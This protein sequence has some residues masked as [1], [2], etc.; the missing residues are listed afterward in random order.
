V[1]VE[2]ASNRAPIPL[3]RASLDQLPRDIERPRYDLDNVRAGIVH[4]GLGGFHRAHMARYT[5]DLMML[6][7]SALEW[8][9]L[10]AGLLPQ[11]HRMRDALAPQDWLYT[12]AER[13]GS[14]ERAVA[15]GALTGMI[16]AAGASE[17]LLEAIDRPSTRIVSITVTEHGYCLNPSTRRL[18][19]EHPLIRR[20]LAE[21]T[22][23]HSAIGILVEAC[24]RRKTA[25]LPAFT[26]L[27]CDNIPH[28]GDVT[29]RAVLDLAAQRDRGLAAWIEDN[30]RFPNGM[31]D[32]ITPVTR[33]EDIAALAA[34]H[35]IADNWPVFS[36]TF[37]QWVV[38]DDF[39]CRRP[40]WEDVGVQFVRDVAPY[41]RMKLRLLNASHLAIAGPA[42]LM[43]YEY[44]DEAMG[45]ASLRLYMR[46]LMDRE[47]GPTLLPVPGIDLEA[48]KVTL[49]ERFA[50]TAIKDLV[51]RVNT[52]A[53]LNYLIDPIVDQ[54]RSGGSIDLLALAV[55]AWI[56]RVR[57][58]DEAGRPIE[59]RHPLAGLLRERAVAG[60]RDPLPVL[61][62]APLFG[63]LA[64][65]RQF[66]SA[67]GKWLAALYD[68]GAARTLAR[69]VGRESRSDPEDVH[70]TAP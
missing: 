54:L 56:R 42:R 6:S 34:R 9:I 13:N 4:L 59:I 21:P 5:H 46:A 62:I 17:S 36:E 26:I 30:V 35:R 47:T 28:N 40:R 32:R 63:D 15:V 69:A 39:T 70:R 65:N 64:Q 37:S 38:E 49:V 51:E 33:P 7:P 22:R 11:D 60:G 1:D 3:C 41:E 19:S 20:D 44:I 24:R 50:N 18:D 29:R 10:G 68:V 12:L 45:N 48:Y 27:S 25:N 14:D 66:V 2:N 43:G 16:H 8:G 53:P 61:G 57:G 23:P 31:V 58:E 52:D 67:V 55:A